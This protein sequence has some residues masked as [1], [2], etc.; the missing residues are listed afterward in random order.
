MRRL[1]MIILGLVLVRP[2]MAKASLYAGGEFRRL[3]RACWPTFHGPIRPSG[4][5]HR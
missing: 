2:A 5:F 1:C 3:A 4:R